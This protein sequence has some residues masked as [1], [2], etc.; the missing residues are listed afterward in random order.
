MLH[1]FY[2]LLFHSLFLQVTWH[3]SCRTV[4]GSHWLL[5]IIFC[6]LQW[7]S[8]GH[9]NTLHPSKNH[10]F[11]TK[12]ELASIRK[13]VTTF[14]NKN[15]RKKMKAHL[16]ATVHKPWDN[17]LSVL[18]ASHASVWQ[19]SMQSQITSGA[20]RHF[21]CMQFSADEASWLCLSFWQS[22]WEVLWALAPPSWLPLSCYGA[23]LHTM[24][25]F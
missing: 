7:E 11:S 5:L 23:M 25:L 12:Y 9:R 24:A 17:I 19:R 8:W 18:N 6:Y 16:H 2:C 14:G 10:F 15:W 20:K 3:S 1:N 13:I 21:Y 4:L 22:N